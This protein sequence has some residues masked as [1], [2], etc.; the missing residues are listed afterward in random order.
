MYRGHGPSPPRCSDGLDLANR[1]L[2]LGSVL[3]AV[4]RYGLHHGEGVFDHR[5]KGPGTFVVLEESHEL[6]G[7][8]S[9]DEDGF[10]ADTRTAL[11]ESLFRRSRALGLRL[12]AVAQNPA[13][14]PAAVTSNTTT[15][16]LHR[17][18]DKADRDKVFSMINWSNMIGQQMR[19]WRYLGEMPQGYCIARLDAK[20]NYLQSA[21]V[22]FLTDPAP[23]V[24]LD[25]EASRRCA[26]SI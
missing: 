2:I 17:V 14:I 6:F 23:M 7:D 4:Y 16:L 1:R 5:G 21:P 3:M 19:E 15:V 25:D 8:R 12:V 22:Q 26:P 11:Y 18:Y 20:D 24:G 9:E 10:S 13:D